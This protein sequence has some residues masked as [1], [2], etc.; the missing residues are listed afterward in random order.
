[1]LDRSLKM[2]EEK[3]KGSFQCKGVKDIRTALEDKSLDAIS[4]ATPNHWHS[5][6]TIWGAQ[7]GKHVY[8]E[9][10]MSHDVYEGRVAVDAA[11]R[12]RCRDPAR[13]PIA[14]RRQESWFA[15][16]DPIWQVWEA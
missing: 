3:S 5:L 7:A 14:K 6:M 16:S 1:M 8:V 2:L 13:N 11:K 10:P 9:K 15:R 4:V 12:L